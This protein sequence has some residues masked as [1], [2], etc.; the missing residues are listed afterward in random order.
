MIYK[1]ETVFGRV[2]IYD[3]RSFSFSI[4]A[5]SSD[6]RVLSAMP[7]LTSLKKVSIWYRY[8]HK[9]VKICIESIDEAHLVH[10]MNFIEANAVRVSLGMIIL[11]RSRP[12]HHK[13]NDDMAL[14]N[15]VRM[16]PNF[17]R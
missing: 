12:K 7:L 3:L 9:I 8:N 5:N 2:T 11:S 10:T 16:A 1:S 13:K 6:V 17:D 14:K 15:E 4:F